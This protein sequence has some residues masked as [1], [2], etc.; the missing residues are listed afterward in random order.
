MHGTGFVP[1]TTLVAPTALDLLGLAG[2]EA[3]RGHSL[4][5]AGA[6]AVAS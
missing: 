3:M 1:S 2:P 4:L 6:A 5:A